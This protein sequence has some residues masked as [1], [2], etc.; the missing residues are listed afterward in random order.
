MDFDLCSYTLTSTDAPIAENDT[1]AAYKKVLA[2]NLL[3]SSVSSDITDGEGAKPAR[4]LAFSEKAPEA[5]EGH[6]NS[7]RVLYSQNARASAPVVRGARHIPSAPER[8][9]DG[10]DLLDDYYLNLL[11]WSASNVLAVALG[12]TVYLWNAATGTCNELMTTKEGDHVCSVSWMKE[13]GSDCLAIGTNDK[14]VQLWDVATTKRLRTMRSHAARVGAMDWNVNVLSTGSRDGYIHHHDVREAK[15]HVGTLQ[16]HEQEVCGLKWSPD[17][18]QLASGGND[19]VLNIWDGVTAGSSATA[20][21]RLTQHTAAVKALAWCP[22]QKGTLASGGGTADRCIRFWNTTTGAQLNHIDTGSQVRK[23]FAV[24]TAWMW[25]CV[26]FS[27]WLLTSHRR[28]NC[29]RPAAVRCLFCTGVLAGVVAARQG[30]PV[31][32]RLLREPVV[33]VE[34]SQHDQGQGADGPHGARAAHGDVPGRQHCL[35][36]G[37]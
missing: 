25:M 29:F 16:G 36:R 5:S 11:D 32:T 27:E 19:N 18:T 21:H 20:R 10:P 6:L 31:V 35:L 24:A 8:I 30:D 34:L 14:Q 15:H 3:S 23:S 28:L 9:L 37:G 12:S 4:V 1:K 33:P 17:G 2:S 22:W 7:M 26:G 13:G